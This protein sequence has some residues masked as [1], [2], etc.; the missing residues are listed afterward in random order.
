L[1][2]EQ[3]T[4]GQLADELKQT[5]VT[6]G[7]GEVVLHHTWSP[8]V[9]QYRGQA[10]WTGIR[11]YHVHERGWS[12]IGYHYGIGPDSTVWKLRPAT[13]SGAH[14]LNRNQHTI[15][16]AMVGNF[17]VEDPERNGLE[18]AARVVG[19]L[20]ARYQLK[21]E[22]IRFH[23]EFADKTCPGTRLDLAQ[24]RLRVAR[25]MEDEGAP[26]PKTQTVRI[27]D[28]KTGKVTGSFELVAG[29][30]HIADQRKVYVKA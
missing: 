17:D 20:V 13:K 23:R 19:L 30:D 10:T 18:M 9:A 1:A 22:N 3:I 7:V 25:V 12:D 6:R 5:K 15:G 11:N 24:F 14:V 16:V 21:P 26:A 29:G 2:I 28:Y 4:L 27:V 8:T